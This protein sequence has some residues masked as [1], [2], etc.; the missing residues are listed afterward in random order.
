L[1]SRIRSGVIPTTA[2]CSSWCSTPTWFVT[3]GT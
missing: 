2:P 3:P 1:A